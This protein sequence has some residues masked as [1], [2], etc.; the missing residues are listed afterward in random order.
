MGQ[1]LP[2]SFVAEVRAAVAGEAVRKAASGWEVYTPLAGS[3]V[4]AVANN[5]SDLDD[6]VDA[7]ANL[8]LGTLATQ[9]ASNVAVTGGAITGTTIDGVSIKSYVDNL[10]A[11][12]KWKRSVQV[13]TTGPI[14]LAT[15]LE[16]GD[17]IDGYTL[18]AGDRVLV[19]D[20]ASGSENGIWI[21]PASGPPSRADDASSA[22]ELIAASVFVEQGATNADLAFV[23]TND[24]ITLGVTAIVF[25]QFGASLDGALLAA[26]NLSDLDD[27]A[28]AR[29][30]LG[31]GT[32]AT[33]DADDFVDVATNQTVAG[34][35]TLTG[36]TVCEVGAAGASPVLI[37]QSGGTPGTDELQLSHDGSDGLVRS[38]SGEFRLVSLGNLRLFSSGSASILVRN[39]G[40]SSTLF[41]VAGTGDVEIAGALNV[42]GKLTV[43]R[44]INT[45]TASY[46]LALDDASKVVEMNVGSANDV[47]VPAN[48]S[49]AFPVGTQIDVV[50]LG[51]GQTT[52][53]ADGGVTIRSKD[54]NLKIS[55]QYVGVTLY[56]RATDEWV[57]VGDLEA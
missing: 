15:A 41:G 35:K 7:R 14:T 56:K 5:L 21:V 22:A 36:Q 25:V 44:S 8:G 47:T 2:G 11:G 37:R 10:V 53:V 54:G 16:N 23:C 1:L 29:D 12:L 50:Q 18:V 19:K 24:A 31:L 52:I 57:L 34:D 49:V 40:D 28:D 6:A 48:S 30:N 3:G 13:A 4:L 9:N 26:N 27:P 39:A 43:K 17:A 45:Q 32:M 42:G 46:A 33:E 20:Q 51:A 55:S 38:M